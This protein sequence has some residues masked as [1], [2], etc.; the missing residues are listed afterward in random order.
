MIKPICI[1]V[2]C[3]IIIFPITVSNAYIKLNYANYKSEVERINNEKILQ[4]IIQCESGG[5]HEN[6]WGD[7]G[8]SYGWFQFQKE[9]FYHI[10]KKMG[11]K[12]AKWKSKKDQF[13]IAEW[14][15][16]NGYANWWSCYR[17]LSKKGEL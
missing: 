15:I 12:N 1:L 10:S 3:L 16:K 7:N 17:I 11:F 5:L 13:I 4:K 6:V 8:K 2:F 9:S 14:G